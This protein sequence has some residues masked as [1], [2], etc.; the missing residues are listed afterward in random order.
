MVADEGPS[1]TPQLLWRAYRVPIV[2]G[3]LSLVCLFLSITIF[4]KEYQRVTPIQ[5][6]SDLQTEKRGAAPAADAVL[7]VDV[8]GAVV[9][10]GVY[11]LPVGSRV[12][13]VIAAAGGITAQADNSSIS[14]SI[15]RAAKLTD[16]AKIYIPFINTEHD[17]DAAVSDG[18]A[19][20]V[21]V[22]VNTA[23]VSQ[24]DALSG[25][26]LVTAQRIV[27]GR[28]Y[29]RLEELVEKKILSASLFHKLKDQLTL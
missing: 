28:P 23:T 27:A 11:R 10:P 6:S 8:E 1:A 3:F 26:G 20:A 13:D 16:G 24:L 21:G 18:G 19:A 7:T 15:N 29:L 4:I 25:I 9:S 17:A 22:N 2:F 12:E 14:R 5:F